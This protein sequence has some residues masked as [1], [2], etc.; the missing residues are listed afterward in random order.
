MSNQKLS[1]EA[2]QLQR[3]IIWDWLN[4]LYEV[5]RNA[6]SMW[7]RAQQTA[8]NIDNRAGGW[9]PSFRRRMKAAKKQN[10]G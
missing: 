9:P 6:A 5:Q 3:T 10:A 2:G 7:I 4:E 1:T 8:M